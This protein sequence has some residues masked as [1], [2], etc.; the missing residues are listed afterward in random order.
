MVESYTARGSFF[1]IP[2]YG[3]N[4]S[5]IAATIVL[6]IRHIRIHL[7]HGKEIR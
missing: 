4:L 2:V 5:L 3:R 1:L 7:E 6:G